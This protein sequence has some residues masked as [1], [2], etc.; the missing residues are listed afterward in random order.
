MTFHLK[1]SWVIEHALKLVHSCWAE[2]R[3][4]VLPSGIMP[5]F[6]VEHMD[7]RKTTL[8]DKDIICYGF[9]LGGGNSAHMNWQHVNKHYSFLPEANSKSHDMLAVSNTSQSAS[10][11]HLL[12]NTS[13]RKTLTSCLQDKPE[14]HISVSNDSFYMATSLLTNQGFSHR[15]RCGSVNYPVKRAADE[16]DLICPELDLQT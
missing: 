5:H 14:S 6:A 10:K 9:F 11:L 2:N 4:S 13:Q 1:I 8:Q 12:T 15:H 7:M 3:F 16:V